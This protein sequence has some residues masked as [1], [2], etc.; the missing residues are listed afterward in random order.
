MLCR[1]GSRNG[2]VSG[3]VPVYL[4]VYDLTPIN[5]YAYWFGLGV[6][7]SGVQGSLLFFFL[8]THFRSTI[9][10][11]KSD[12]GYLW[13]FF[14]SKKYLIFFFQF[15]VLSM[16]L[17]HMNTRRRGYLK[18]N[19]RGVKGSDSGKRYWL[20]KRMWVPVRWKVWWK[21]LLLSIEGMLITS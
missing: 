15:M 18:V 7:H 13:F 1:K 9:Y 19:R 16:R 5:S 8:R 3:S 11:I 20:G 21:S 10:K 14:N 2:V 12:D 6:Y 4:N 17:G